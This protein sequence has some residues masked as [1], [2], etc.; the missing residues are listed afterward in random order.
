MEFELL[1]VVVWKLLVQT[2][3]IKLVITTVTNKQS[4]VPYY[5]SIIDDHRQ[6]NMTH[7]N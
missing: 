3:V 5:S 6:W 4:L 7:N 1:E 2:I